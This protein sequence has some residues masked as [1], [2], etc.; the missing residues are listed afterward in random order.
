MVDDDLKS[1]KLGDQDAWA[2]V[3]KEY[4][5]QLMRMARGRVGYDEA[6]DVVQEVWK[7]A[8]RNISKINDVP[9]LFHWLIAVTET[10]CCDFIE[11]RL[12]R[13]EASI[14]GPAETSQIERLTEDKARRQEKI[15]VCLTE[16]WALLRESQPSQRLIIEKWVQGLTG[17]EIAE[18]LRISI[19]EVDRSRRAFRKKLVVRLG[20]SRS[21]NGSEIDP[22]ERGVGT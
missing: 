13:K 17:P 7:K 12:R 5:P 9:H 2:R 3:F 10:T 14:D 18:E 19:K 6:E 4:K 21:A 16:F 22:L 1:A 20:F 11:R 8:F 15:K